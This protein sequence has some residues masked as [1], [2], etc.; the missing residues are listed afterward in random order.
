MTEKLLSSRLFSLSF[1]FILTGFFP[2]TSNQNP[3]SKKSLIESE[4]ICIDPE[5][6]DTPRHSDFFFIENKGQWD[7]NIW[8]KLETNAAKLF[9][10]KNRL[11]F[12]LI[13]PDDL[14]ERS[15][16]HAHAGEHEG[17][18]P[19][20]IHCHRFYVDFVGASAQTGKSAI[21]KLSPYYNYLIGNDPSKHASNVGLYQE[22]FYENLYD[23]IDMR[24]Y[25]RGANIKYDFLLEAGADPNQILA[26]YSY[27]DKLFLKDGKLH[28]QTSV[29]EIIEQEPY[30]Y[31]EKNGERIKV[32]CDFRLTENRLSFVFPEGYDDSLPLVIDPELVFASYSGA[33]GDNWGTTATYDDTGN[34]YG[35][36]VAFGDYPTTPGAFIRNQPGDGI[37][38]SDPGTMGISKFSDDGTSLI[39]STFLGGDSFEIPHSMIVN[40]RNQLV[41]MG[42][43]SSFNYPTANAFDNSFGAG[44]NVEINGQFNY[45][46]GSDIV[47]TVLNENGT[48]IIGS[49]FVGGNANDGLHFLTAGAGL[50]YSDEVR[51]EVILDE[52]DNI[53]VASTT[54]STDFPTTSGAFQ[55]S[56]SGGGEDA[57]VFK[58]S[59]NTN[60]LIWSTFVGGSEFD[61]AFSLKLD[62][63]QNA[64][65]CGVTNSVDFP[66]SPNA[67]FATKGPNKSNGYV[68]KLNSD[69]SQLTGATYM[70][71]SDFSYFVDLD[72]QFD[73]YVIGQD[74]SRR[75]PITSGVYANSSGSTILHKFSG[76][77]SS[78]GFST[79]LGSTSP[80][81][82]LVPSAFLVDVCNRIYISGWGG[83]SNPSGGRIDGMP[84][85][86]NA[87]QSNTDG[88]DFYLMVLQ[89]QAQDLEYATYF[90]GRTSSEH[91]DGGTSRFDK[92]G[93][94]YQAVCAGCGGN[95][96]FPTSNGAVSNLNRAGN[97]NL[98]VFKFDFQ[99]GAIN[100]DVMAGPETS[101]CAPLTVDFSNRTTGATTYEWDFN[102]GTTSS[103]R[104]PV[105]TFTLPGPYVIRMIASIEADCIVPDTTFLNIEVFPPVPGQI[106]SFEICDGTPTNI[107]S[108]VSLPGTDYVWNTGETDPN[109]DIA[110]GGVFWVDATEPGGGCP[111][112]DSF[113]IAGIPNGTN[114]ETYS[115]CEG[116]LRTLESVNQFAQASYIW[117]DGS[118]DP[119]LEIDDIGTY[120]VIAERSGCLQ[121]DTF[122]ILP[123]SIILDLEVFDIDC[124]GQ[125]SGLV[126]ATV[127]GG[128]PPYEYSV[129]M[130][131]FDVI[132]DFDNL[133]PGNFRI[134]ARDQNGCSDLKNAI[135]DLPPPVTVNL[136]A[137]QTICLGDST[138]I[139]TQV[140]ID[141]TEVDSA[142]WTALDD[143]NCPGCLEQ[144]VRP[145]TT[146]T[147]AVRIKSTDGCSGL[148]SVTVMVQPKRPIYVPSAFS[149]NNDGINDEFLL[150]SRPHLVTAVRIFQV[151]D[152][153]GNLVFEQRDFAPNDPEFGWDG[154]FR[155]KR[156]NPAVFAW[157]AEVEFID[158]FIEK[159][160]GDVTLL[161]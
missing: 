158:G 102:D 67:A 91:V 100:A 57:V 134:A 74:A 18:E 160:K 120:Y 153:W 136:G 139:I 88:S 133:A 150:Y 40:S 4:E 53:Y 144:I 130:A 72:N 2:F 44:R 151:F 114:T 149:P 135:I 87:F 142:V 103:L 112:R 43:T 161:K 127:V 73:V 129:N 83:D 119:F 94:I 108:S 79:R 68:A 128:T 7:A 41:I 58:L 26:E 124:V 138:G 8:Y 96:D 82:V 56:H 50:N 107:G 116:Q 111:K 115:L 47:V 80:G 147:Y 25:N 140:N 48:G 60:N 35:G 145:V 37:F 62:P 117:Q 148:D 51:G 154:I 70:P 126:K 31:Q 84:L 113:V 106:S 93:I 27:T 123:D 65:F 85:T 34:L 13:N 122:I 92:K 14:A 54:Y 16:R 81:A 110:T 90:G 15:H 11:N 132:S 59:P 46:F 19:V 66:V 23:G 137:D 55:T 24:L 118:G 155:G 1:L 3:S 42:T 156:M 30:A 131:P 45:G 101:G 49:T 38:F 29:N 76:D 121:I 64:Y 75:Y 152:R 20:P 32:A 109:I 22:V 157:H 63:A 33:R 52:S 77:L 36:G 9:V 159:V 5:E 104:E 61:A 89:P 21:K 141:P 86:P 143:P 17:D 95:S 125:D 69:G 146:T 12:L 6:D 98:G 39:Y 97:C 10:E 99:L 78:T 28:I 105:H 71:G